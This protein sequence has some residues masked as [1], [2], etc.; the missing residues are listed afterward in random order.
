M[1]TDEARAALREKVARAMWDTNSLD[2]FVDAAIAVCLEEAAKVADEFAEADR[3]LI[4]TAEDDE[5][6][7]A[8]QRGR[9]KAKNIAAAIRAMKSSPGSGS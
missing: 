9:F 2:A 4:A 6:L 7:A 1:A 5:E 3:K 8:F